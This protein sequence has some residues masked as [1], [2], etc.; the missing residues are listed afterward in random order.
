MKLGTDRGTLPDEQDG[1]GYHW[2]GAGR[3]G[4]PLRRSGMGQG[5]L[6]EVLNELGDPREGPGQVRERTRRS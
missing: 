2:G 5:M 6:F 4:G 1:S 3:V